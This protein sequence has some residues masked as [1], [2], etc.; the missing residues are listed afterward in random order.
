MATR[1]P[2]SNS[3]IAQV[4]FFMSVPKPSYRIYAYWW[5][6]LWKVCTF[7]HLQQIQLA[8]LHTRLVISCQSPI[9]KK[10]SGSTKIRLWWK[11]RL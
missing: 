9:K 11:I 2:I 7:L 1:K 10:R 5:F 4:N 3:T 6:F 8:P